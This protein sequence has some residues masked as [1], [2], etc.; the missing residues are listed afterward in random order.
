MDGGSVTAPNFGIFSKD[1][2]WTIENEGVP[3]DDDV[4]MTPRLVIEGADPQLEK[5]VEVVLDRL[6]TEGYQKTPRPAYPDRSRGSGGGGG[7]R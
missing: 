2:E 1:G 5:A 7:E 3:P 6:G 4:E